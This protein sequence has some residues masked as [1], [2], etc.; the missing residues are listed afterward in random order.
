MGSI[1]F[2]RARRMR[3]RGT[4]RSRRNRAEIVRELSWAASFAA[5]S[6]KWCCSR[7]PGSGAAAAPRS[8]HRR[9]D[10]TASPQPP[11]RRQPF[12]SRCRVDVLDRKLWKGVADVH[13]EANTTP[14]KVPAAGGGWYRA[15]A[16]PGR[17]GAPAVDKFPRSLGGRRRAPAKTTPTYTPRVLSR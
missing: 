14:L 9:G 6:D 8:S 1:Y 10:G 15:K 3:A 17:Y 13:A 7:A 16:D 11:V 5:Q 12:T 2:R 4:R